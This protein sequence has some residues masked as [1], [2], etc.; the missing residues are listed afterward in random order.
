MAPTHMCRAACC[1]LGIFVG[2]RLRCLGDPKDLVS[3]FGGY[4]SFSVTTPVGQVGGGPGM[5]PWCVCVF[6]AGG[7]H[8]WGEG[9]GRPAGG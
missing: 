4:M 7:V 5:Q 1:R 3:R 8:S 2:G 6:V 9:G